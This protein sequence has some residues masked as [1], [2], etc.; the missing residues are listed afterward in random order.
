MI[1]L[2]LSIWLLTISVFANNSKCNV[3]SSLLKI[4]AE[5]EKH[6]Q[7]EVGYEY[8]ISF[9]NKRDAK[10]T[11][12]KIGK[13]IFL[14]KRTIDCKNKQL[15]KKITNFLIKQK[16]TNLDLGAFQINYKYHKM[17]IEDYF[18][19]KKSYLKACGLLS[20]LIKN[21][22]YSW[23]T[24]ARYHS[25]TPEYNYKYLKKISMLNKKGD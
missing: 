9:N 11:K 10:F 1:K 21:Y 19:F 16:I 2:I 24:I 3:D 23:R 22:G 5:V 25:A 14:D 8:L 17:E 15:C 6:N 13:K 18:S 12:N 7:K 20:K 4:I